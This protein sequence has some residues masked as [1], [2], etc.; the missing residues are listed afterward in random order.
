LGSRDTGD[1]FLRRFSTISIFPG[2]SAQFGVFAF[3][4]LNE[5]ANDYRSVLGITGRGENTLGTISILGRPAKTCW[6]RN[7]MN[8][9]MK[10]L[11]FFSICL[12]MIVSG[13]Q[14]TSEEDVWKDF[15]DWVLKQAPNSK[16]GDLIRSY[17]EGLLRQGIADDEV[18]RRMGV[19]SNSIFTRRKGVELLW[20]KVYAGKNPV[21]IQGPSAVVMSAI[22]GRK[23]GKAL[24][25]GMGQGRNSV[26]LA[27][28]GWDVTGFDPSG[29]GIRIARSNAD[30]A[31]VK[32]RA[33]VARDDEFRYGEDQWDL[34]VITYVRDLTKEDAA[35][36]WK[37]L[38]PGGIVVYENGADANNS[39]LRAFL[40]YQII[41]FEDIQT[42]PEWNP[43]TNRIRVQRLIA[44]KTHQASALSGPSCIGPS[45]ASARIPEDRRVGSIEGPAADPCGRL[46]ARSH[47]CF[48][49]PRETE[50]VHPQPSDS[51]FVW[52]RRATG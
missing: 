7:M 21:F 44:Q 40:G 51:L 39:V 29:E 32:I 19:V 42:I 9:Q 46:D 2:R 3:E 17:R 37:A 52:G 5:I 23:P 8:R 27:G 38:R 20:D 34:I 6:L 49:R 16:P 25:I 14:S 10:S 33:L 28:Q 36:F 30:K 1:E 48:L 22:E 31:G 24:D 45:Q 26:Y 35:Q 47:H 12:C 18:R 43:E 50:R 13:Q 41:Q 4:L 15:T 11:V